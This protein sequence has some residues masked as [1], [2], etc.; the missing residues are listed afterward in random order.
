MFK[1][2]TGEYLE[3]HNIIEHCTFT[4]VDDTQH[5]VASENLEDLESYM[6]QLHLLLIL[7]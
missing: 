3:D 1:R 5:I 7:L 4:Y 6:Q 2:I